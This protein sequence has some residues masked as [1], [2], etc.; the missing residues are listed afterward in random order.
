LESNIL[1]CPEE[2]Y[3][4]LHAI[5]THDAGYRESGKAHA[6]ASHDAII[7][8]PERFFI[9]YENLA[10]AIAWIALAHGLDDL[11][12]VPSAFP[13]DFLS[14][15]LEFDLQFLGAL[16]LLADEMD[17][18]YLRVFNRAGQERSQRNS[19]YHVEIGPQ[20]VKL[21]TKPD[22]SDQW[23]QLRKTATH[24]QLRLDRVAPILGRRGV[25]LEQV[26]L[27]PTVWAEQGPHE[28]EGVSTSRSLSPRSTKRVF[29]LLDRTVLGAQILQRM[30]LEYGLVTVVPVSAAHVAHYPLPANE[31]YSGITWML[32]ED[33]ETPICR[34]I[35]DMLLKNTANGGGL[36]L[37]PFV[38]WSVS[39]GINDQVQDALPVTLAGKWIEGQS[40]RISVIRTHPITEGIKPFTIENTYEWLTVKQGAQSI[41]EDSAG[42]PFL[43][44][45]SFGKGKVAY[46]NACSHQCMELREMVSP[47]QQNP[48][49]GEVIVRTVAWACET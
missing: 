41:M 46:V 32:G 37:F 5:Y 49:V 30:Q 16:L 9:H 20:I 27:Y 12:N 31:P 45:G 8:H 24:I 38:A 34:E 11:S 36:V 22:S 15:T 44:V 40:N 1:L 25:K 2:V 26:T 19:I 3:L 17:Q 35:M 43:V 18:A 7:E 10:K 28:E 47:W 23:E 4:L 48:V 33:F 21:K 14:K 13:V 29:F 6:K 42:N 39:Q